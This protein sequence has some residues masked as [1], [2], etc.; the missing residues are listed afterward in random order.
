L[1]RRE[2]TLEKARR[3]AHAHGN[4]GDDAQEDY[5]ED[6]EYQDKR[7]RI[8]GYDPLAGR[9]AQFG[10]H[11][12]LQGDAAT[13]LYKLVFMTEMVKHGTTPKA[14]SSSEAT[15]GGL[16]TESYYSDDDPYSDTEGFG[17]GDDSSYGYEPKVPAR[18]VYRRPEEPARVVNQLLLAWTS[19]S[20]S[21]IEKGVADEQ[22]T[23]THSSSSKHAYVESDDE[24]EGEHVKS[25]QGKYNW[26]HR[27]SHDCNPNENSTVVFLQFSRKKTQNLIV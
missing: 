25:S 6:W 23:A 10:Q 27:V 1:I 24:S 12:H 5:D 7:G 9:V 26:P 15:R 2:R 20:Q 16:H 19:L 3:R 14:P 4:L 21:E 8:E 22:P 17:T 13:F 18:N 11:F